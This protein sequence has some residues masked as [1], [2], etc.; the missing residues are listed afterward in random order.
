MRTRLSVFA[1]IAKIVLLTSIAF[2]QM[3]VN[4]R[5][6]SVFI[7]SQD[8]APVFDSGNI[9]NYG[10]PTFLWR[11]RG[12]LDMQVSER[13]YIFSDL[14]IEPSGLQ[15]DF[16]AIRIYL[17]QKQTCGLQTGVLGTFIGNVTPRRSS[18]YNPMIHLPIMYDYN[19]VLE[20]SAAFTGEEI[21]QLRG[22]GNGMPI[23]Y[24]AVYRP[25]AEVFKTFFDLVDLQ[26]G[27]FNSAPSN[28]YLMGQS[29]R[30]N[31]SFRAGI[32]PV[33]GMNIGISFNRGP[34]LGRYTVYRIPDDKAYQTLWDIDFSF[35]RGHLAFFSEAV[36]NR[37]SHPRLQDD[38]GVTG[39]YLELKYKFHPHFFIAGRAGQ[40]FFDEIKLAD[41][42]TAKWDDNV[43]R[44]EASLGYYV[45]RE[46]LAKIVVQMNRTDRLD[47]DDDYIAV[48]LSAGF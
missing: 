10:D 33:M 39:Y 46:T 5:M 7:D 27:I 38:L 47:P 32:R 45:V 28:P 25:G 26:A 23:F 37:W 8:G 4:G 29:G 14:R 17:D 11:F 21:Y 48:Q 15:I 36:Y 12:Y 19:T 31:Y 20:G 16:A 44:F 9:I 43:T 18:K 13:S 1:I 6:E 40:L 34:Y 30:F 24:L 3:N 41:T 2:S 35:E 42:V 22:T